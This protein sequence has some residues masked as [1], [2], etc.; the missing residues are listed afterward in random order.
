MAGEQVSRNWVKPASSRCHESPGSR[1]ENLQMP[2]AATSMTVPTKYPSLRKWCLPA[3]SGLALILAAAVFGP[4]QNWARLRGLPLE[5]RAKLVENLKKF[6][7][8]YSRRQQDSLRQ[9]DGKIHALPP[10]SRAHY[11]AV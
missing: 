8:L 4:D 7:L 10:E 3:I 5:R 11:L 9:L 2:R 6:D 1:S